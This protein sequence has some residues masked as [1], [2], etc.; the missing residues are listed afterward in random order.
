MTAA[1]LA[2]MILALF[3]ALLSGMP[4]MLA[5]GGVPLL[6]ALAAMPFGLFDPALLHAFAGRVE[7][8]MENAPLA[9]I[10]LFVL[11]GAILDRSG[12]SA[13]MLA[14]IAGLAGGSPRRLAL[15]VLAVSALLAAT[16]GVVG[17]TIVMLATVALPGMLRAGVDQRQA[18]GLIAASGTLGQLIPPSILLI[19]LADQVSNAAAEAA[20]R[21]G[22]FAATPVAIGDLFAAC[23]GPGLLLIGLY[24][25]WIVFALARRPAHSAAPASRYKAGEILPAFA[26]PLLLIAC[27]LGS[28]LA[29]IATPTEAAGAGAAGALILAALSAHRPALKEMMLQ[30]GLDTVRL[31]GVVFSIVLAA[32]MFALVFR[33]FGGDL[34]IESAL[35]GLPGEAGVALLAVLAA[36][37]LLGFMLEFIEIVMIV[38][39]VAGPVLFALGVDPLW[40][41]VLLALNLQT[42]FLTPPFGLA[43]FYFRAAAPAEVSTV[44]LYR[45]VVPY[46]GLQLLALFVVW[47]FPTLATWLPAQLL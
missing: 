14:A 1:L 32:S 6:F 33:G 35:T 41:A 45:G 22:N 5:I 18:S 29:G 38:V 27:V 30:A 39:P 31:T 26:P 11:M 13:R 7:G 8:M 4:A 44:A 47:L 42:S 12:L 20:R 16:T 19:L 46:V 10:P 25:A 24:A 34:L 43:L 17:A 9:A 21:A 15:A 37:F 2:C 36:V 3:A 40:F 23:V 28:I